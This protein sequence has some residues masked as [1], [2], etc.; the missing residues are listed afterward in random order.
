MREFF[1]EAARRL[2]GERFLLGGSGWDEYDGAPPNVQRMGHVYTRDH[3]AF[4]CS[5]RAVLNINRD[6]MARNGF[7]PPTRVFEAAGAGACL[8]MD[9]WHG[10]EQFLEPQREVLVARSG[11]EVAEILS[12]LSPAHARRIGDA[13]LARVLAEHTYT[14][15]ALAFEQAVAGR[16]PMGAMA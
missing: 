2:P 10:I 8:I 16:L 9:A 1:F 5:P 7:S 15:R 13:A 14:H 4:N 3:N 11:T 6:S 12:A